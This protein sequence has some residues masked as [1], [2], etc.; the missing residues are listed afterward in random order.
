MQE[1]G[2]KSE[3]LREQEKNEKRKKEE[4]GDKIPHRR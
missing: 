2:R 1:D 3:T 4:M